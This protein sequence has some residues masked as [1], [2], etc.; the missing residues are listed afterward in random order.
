MLKVCGH[1]RAEDAAASRALGV[2]MI[3]VVGVRWSP[4]Y[5]PPDKLPNFREI[6]GEF[7]YVVDY[8][9]V[10]SII[11]VGR[12]SGAVQVHRHMS[13]HEM[14]RLEDSGLKVIARVPASAEGAE[15]IELVRR[16]NLTPLV[17]STGD[18][19]GTADL[20]FFDD[21]SDSGIAGGIGV[22][23]LRKFLGVGARF[24][25]VSRGSEDAPGVKSQ[26]RIM[27]LLQLVKEGAGD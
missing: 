23:N 22:E 10:D 6:V 17:H 13:E 15:Y 27:R 3:G 7:F 21:L 24:V 8:E 26:W 2:D 1:V 19:L 16:H 12:I 18:G 9:S 4:R 20:R 14:R 11:N 25:D 5:V